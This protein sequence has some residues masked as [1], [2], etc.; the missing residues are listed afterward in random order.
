MNDVLALFL[1]RFVTVY[2]D[3][4]LI[5]WD[6]VEQHRG[7]VCSVLTPLCKEGLHLKQEKC[8]FHWEKVKY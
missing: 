3:D 8:K 4:I 6:T 2:L 5:Y 7:H 1:D